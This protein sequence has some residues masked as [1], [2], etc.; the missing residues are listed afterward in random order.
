MLIITFQNVNQVGEIADYDWVVYV[1][2]QE[3]AR[4]EVLGHDRTE[5]WKKLVNM[6][7]GGAENGNAISS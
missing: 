4:G 7:F 6:A 3:I 5:G 2:R 1:N